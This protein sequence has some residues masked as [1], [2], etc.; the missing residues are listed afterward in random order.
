[1]YFDV[2]SFHLLRKHVLDVVGPSP[3]RET[4]FVVIDDSAGSDEA[5]NELDRY[6]DVQ[7]IG[8]PYS[9]G[10]QRA[11]VLGTADHRRRGARHRRRGHARRGRRRPARGHP[12]PARAARNPPRQR[13]GDRDRPAHIAP[14]VDQLPCLLRVLPRRLPPPRRLGDR[15][16]QLRRVPGLGG[17]PGRLPPELRPVLLVE[18]GQP[19]A[20]RHEGAL[21][22]RRALRRALPD[23]VHAPRHPRAA[24]AHAV[25]RPHRPPGARPLRHR[26]HAVRARAARPRRRGRRGRRRSASRCASRSAPSRS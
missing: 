14:R 22:A 15:Q 23:D 13:P 20:A 19:R 2:E 12:A 10:H 5:I 18:P 26:A 9:L 21:R 7:V 25:P 8:P 3:T 16:R 6:D 1:M 11:L 24:D 4:R 17:A